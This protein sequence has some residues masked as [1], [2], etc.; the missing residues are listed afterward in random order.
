[1]IAIGPTQ[2]ASVVE[3]IDAT[4]FAVVADVLAEAEVARALAAL[5]AVFEQEQSLAATRDW[6]TDEYRVS[7]ALPVK[8]PVFLE[9]CAHPG[10]L[11][12]ARAVL[13][14]DCVL[15]A[16]N[17]LSMVPGGG[18]QP[19]HA[20]HREPA[21]GTCLYL[22]LVCALDPFG[23]ANGATRL[24]PGTHREAVS[25]EDAVRREDDAEVVEMAAGSALAFDGSLLQAGSANTTDRP[26]RALHVFFCRRWVKPHWDFPAM[27]PADVAAALDEERRELLGFTSRPARF[28][29]DTST[30]EWR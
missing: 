22:H 14:A 19:L 7:Y 29:L 25:D 9:L 16:F 27:L 30:I 5:D 8:H 23:P 17:G 11:A 13:G 4:G 12:V 2:L 28:D 20:D 10:L 3:A 6:L 15:A 18:G 1:V 26:R 24:V 21:P